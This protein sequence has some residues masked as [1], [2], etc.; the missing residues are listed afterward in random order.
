MPVSSESIPVRPWS[1]AR[2]AFRLTYAIAQ[3]VFS[4]LNALTTGSFSAAQ[5]P[6]SIWWSDGSVFAVSAIL[7]AVGLAYGVC[8]A[9]HQYKM[10]GT[11]SLWSDMLSEPYMI[12]IE[13][14]FD[15]EDRGK[16]LFRVGL[17]GMLLLFAVFMLTNTVFSILAGGYSVGVVL[18][19]SMIAG[20]YA[21]SKCS[22]FVP[23]VMETRFRVSNL[24]CIM[25]SLPPLWIEATE[26]FLLI[27]SDIS[28]SNVVLVGL[29][30]AALLPLAI[31]AV[32]LLAAG[33]LA[34]L[35]TVVRSIV[36]QFFGYIIPE[37]C[38]DRFRRSMGKSFGRFVPE[39][40]RG[41]VQTNWWV[42][43]S[44]L[45]PAPVRRLSFP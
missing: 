19:F 4:F 32:A 9:V 12:A 37:S 14:I 16:I 36:L 15:E 27:R 42:G 25:C 10:S 1:T 30:V 44:D 43:K 11:R 33:A 29:D 3:T 23:E 38:V 6:G 24:A 21:V 39:W 26:A 8:M 13:G 22:V 2:V 35:H 7:E 17:L 18:F 28:V 34:W 31:V 5:Q 45:R 41:A 20:L 40:T